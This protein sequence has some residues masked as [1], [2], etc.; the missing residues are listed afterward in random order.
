MSRREE[1]LSI[2]SDVVAV[3]TC[4]RKAESLLQNKVD[5]FEKLARVIEH[6]PGLTAN[7]LKMV[8]A[9]AIGQ[10]RPIMTA[11]D[12]LKWLEAPDVLQFVISTGVAPSYV[13]AIDG[14]DQMPNMH[15]QHSVATALAGCEVARMLDMDVPDYLFTAGLLSGIGKL[16]L[17]VYAQVD[18]HD[19]T[20]KAVD[21][22]LAF[23]KVEESLLGINHAEL[24]ALLLEKWGLPTQITDV[25]R[26]HL[27]PDD[28]PTRDPVLDLVHVGNMMARI[29]GIGLGVDGL[30][31]ELSR[32]A[33][34]RLG[35]KPEMVDMA[36]ANVVMELGNLWD[37]F[38]ECAE[39]YCVL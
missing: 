25:V 2:V 3:P 6:D 32:T 7:L 15:L 24:G 8:N 23:D 29:I 26:Y 27:R 9:S 13:H 21:E 14:Y 39:D 1:I 22:Q 35:L 38:L 20:M 10:N 12:A 4:V 11:R 18:M 37:L 28:S 19:L 5:D 36:A 30:N 17:G 31:Y 16:V 34:E 33:V